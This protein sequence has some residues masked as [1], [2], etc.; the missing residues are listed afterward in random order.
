MNGYAFRVKVKDELEK[1]MTS[2]GTEATVCGIEMMA[3]S[4]SDSLERA[5][6]LG[7]AEA[8]RMFAKAVC[9]LH[10]TLTMLAQES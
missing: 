8:W 10:S 6:M 1:L 4:A 7:E 5:G 3:R 2:C 9:S